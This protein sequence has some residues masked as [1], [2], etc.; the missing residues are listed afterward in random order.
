MTIIKQPQEHDLHKA[1]MLSSMALFMFRQAEPNNL[2]EWA[3]SH[4]AQ[5]SWKVGKVTCPMT[6]RTIKHS[7]AMRH[8]MELITQVNF[9][10]A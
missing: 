8:S 3:E 9:L 6:D 5:Q 7:T 1:N 4:E 10:V 2:G